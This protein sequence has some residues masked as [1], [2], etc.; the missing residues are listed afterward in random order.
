METGRTTGANA[1]REHLTVLL[2][3]NDVAFR[4]G[5]RETL[6][7]GGFLVVDE[8]GDAAGAI[9]AASRLNPDICLIEL[10]LP[11]Q[12]PNAIAR[13]AKRSPKTLIVVL[14]HSERPE[15]VV[16]AL[17]RGASGYLLKDGL[18]G[19]R[20]ASTL[21]A[22]HRGEPALSRSLVPYLVDEIRHLSARRITLPTGQVALTPREWEVAELLREGNSTAEIADRL[23]VSPVTVRRHVG[24]LL[25]KLGADS[26]EK[27]VEMIRAYARR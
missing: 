1:A 2:A 15:E 12:G 21:L 20:L 11:G 24:L 14:S 8:V 19:E 7:A 27:A 9:I 26:R 5:V 18:S 16:G 10:G 6:E 3:D 25:R 23:G 22:A 17:T 4:R 13:I